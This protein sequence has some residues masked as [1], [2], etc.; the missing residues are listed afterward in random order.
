M[1]VA[2][3]S[4]F[5]LADILLKCKLFITS[6]SRFVT[7]KDIDLMVNIVNLWRSISQFLEK[8]Y[9]RLNIFYMTTI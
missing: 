1:S 9:F 3:I 5:W 8:P 7:L 4:V 2:E 6:L